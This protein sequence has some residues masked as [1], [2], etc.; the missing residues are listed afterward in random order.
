M[1]RPI[2]YDTETTGVKA[3]NDQIIEIAAYDPIE[4]RT[5]EMFVNPGR[6]IPP[7]ATAI[8]HITDE[9]VAEAPDFSLVGQ[10][11]INF[12]EGD[13]ILIAHNNDGFDVHFL[14]AEFGRHD[15]PM[16]EWKFLDSLKWARRYRR[17]LPRHSLQFLR[18]IYGI[19]ANNAHRALDDVIVL[20]EVFSRMLDD[21]SIDE[22]YELLMKPKEILHMPF[23]KHQGKPLK[24]VP[25]DYVRWLAGNGAFDKPEN[26]Q[27]KQAFEK[28]GLLETTVV[29]S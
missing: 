2:Y 10:E 16:P 28:V 5:F 8:H 13:T 9:M 21:L 3:E 17:D 20:H 15:I 14:R 25:E 7:D 26:E 12:C 1:A 18:E 23:G 11:F 29:G 6:P 22:A 4:N 27:L 19:E 24:D